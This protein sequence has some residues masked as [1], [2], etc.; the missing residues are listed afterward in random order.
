MRHGEAFSNTDGE[1]GVVGS[2]KPLT[3]HGIEQVRMTAEW[4]VGRVAVSQIVSSPYRRTME[5]SEIVAERLGLDFTTDERLREIG[6]GDWTGLPV[7]EVIRL[8]GEVPKE[9]RPFFKPPGGES[10]FDVATRVVSLVGDLER[11]EI[12]DSLLVSHDHPIRMGT[13]LLLRRPMKTWEQQTVSHAS[14]TRLYGRGL[15]WHSDTKVFNVAGYDP[16]TLPDD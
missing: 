4:M 6:K 14:V 3:K 12:S 9:D 8:E 5:T 11:R 7:S 1:R 2:D 13:G 10:W 15:E 16:T